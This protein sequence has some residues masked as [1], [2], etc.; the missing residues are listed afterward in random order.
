MWL[1]KEK[2][3]MYLLGTK[4]ADFLILLVLLFT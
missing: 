3:S 2:N 1:L 4:I